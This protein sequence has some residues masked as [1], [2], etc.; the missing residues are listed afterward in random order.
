MDEATVRE[1]VHSYGL[2][3]KLEYRI[4]RI[5]TRRI[6]ELGINGFDM[7][8]SHISD[9]VD[10]FR[11]PFGEMSRDSPVSQNS[12][13]TL[14]DSIGMQDNNLTLLSGGHVEN[15]DEENPEVLPEE[16]VT[17]ILSGVLDRTDLALFSQLIGNTRGLR[18]F[19]ISPDE[20]LVLAPKIQER[21]EILAKKY[22]ING[23]LIIPQRP[24]IS[25]QFDP[26]FSIRFRRRSF[27]ND[28]LAFFKEHSDI[29]QGLSRS[30]LD[31]VD[32]SLY[33]TLR[34]RGQ[35]DLAI[36]T[37]RINPRI[38]YRG[39]E[40]PLAY[41][42]AH[43]EK[44][45]TLTRS[46]LEHLDTGLYDAL[47]RRK[48]LDAAIPEK[49]ET[50]DFKG[51]PLE[52][53]MANPNFKGISRSEL[54]TLD[55]SLYVKLRKCGQIAQAIPG[56]KPHTRKNYRGYDSPFAY[57]QANPEKYKGVTRTQLRTVDE[58]LYAALLK[59]KQMQ[60]AI[61]ED[62]RGYNRRRLWQP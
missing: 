16:V 30:D 24:V 4:T 21:L 52:V 43:H 58:G 51:N 22:E 25:V 11:A 56:K 53:F 6:A 40:S 2:S 1:I 48:Q 5:A 62:R 61:P 46:E 27:G 57:F 32:G 47:L 8:Y 54:K 18:G 14:L 35:L 23:R 60:Y 41:F 17:G 45:A 37:K 39:Y 49:R 55:Q 20:I 9:L 26:Y 34:N 44:Y 13:L 19:D 50:R 29:Y 28:P 7:A 59:R 15:E 38:K 31:R 36:P 33:Q 42:Q 3:P 10:R 12:S